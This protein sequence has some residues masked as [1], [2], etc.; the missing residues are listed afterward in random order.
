M[1]FCV[2]ILSLCSRAGWGEETPDLKKFLEE[3]RG[4]YND[5]TAR[6]LKSFSARVFLKTTTDENVAKNKELV[7]FSYAWTAPQKDEFSFDPKSPEATQGGMKKLVGKLWLYLT[8]ATVF[9][10][11]ETSPDLKLEVKEGNTVISGKV[12]PY[13]ISSV[14]F[15]TETG[16]LTEWDLKQLKARITFLFTQKEDRFRLDSKNVYAGGKTVRSV[17]RDYRKVNVFSMPILMDV[18]TE[19]NTYKFG[20]EYLT[21]N[22]RPAKVAEMDLKE[23]KA[24]LAE[25]EKGWRG[26]SPEEKIEQLKTL[27]EMDH[28]LVTAVIAKLGLRDRSQEVRRA[29]AKTLGVMKRKNVVPTLIHSMKPNEKDIKTYLH[30]I[31]ALGEL[32]DPRAVKPLSTDWWNQKIGEYGLAAARGKIDALGKIRHVTA[33]DALIETFY[34]TRDDTISRFKENIRNGLK[35]LTR[36]DFIYDRKAWKE[37]WKRNRATHKFEE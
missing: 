2:A 20:I 5:M 30:I 31:W 12:M 27:S 29:A 14:T 36:Q 8:G 37:W 34:L 1:I 15:N 25:F 6:G 3:T 26:W 32:N 22:Q 7:G 24:R 21:I 17:F 10:L 33:V 28:D 9:P 16:K 13:G 23:V 19:K 35:N 4:K 11:L 18:V